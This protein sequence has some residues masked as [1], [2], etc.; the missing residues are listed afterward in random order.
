MQNNKIQFDEP[1]Y[2]ISKKRIGQHDSNVFADF[3]IKKGWIKNEQ[4]ATYIL[5]GVIVFCILIMVWN[6]GNITEEQEEQ[7]EIILP[8]G[9]I[10]PPNL[11]L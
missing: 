2:E 11:N 9:Q 5:L 10:I 4:Q 8:E 3:L 7:E 1:E 6:F